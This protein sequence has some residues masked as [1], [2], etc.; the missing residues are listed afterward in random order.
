MIV[1]LIN[2]MTQLPIPR[3]KTNTGIALSTLPPAKQVDY[4]KELNN[5]SLAL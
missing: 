5:L 3:H 1:A 4:L 2:Y